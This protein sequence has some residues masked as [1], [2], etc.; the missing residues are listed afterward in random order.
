MMIYPAIDIKDGK[1]VRLYKGDFD[2]VTVFNESPA[3]QAMQFVTAGFKWLH[4]V[5]LDGAVNAKPVNIEP[6]VEIIKSKKLKVQIGGG[7]RNMD[8]I[9]FWIAQGVTVILARQRCA[10]LNL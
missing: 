1:C 10:I 2:A 3:K 4:V 7:I 9:E 5:D 8:T 6:V